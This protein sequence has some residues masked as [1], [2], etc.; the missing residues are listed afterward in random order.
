ML[1]GKTSKFPI[2]QEIIFGVDR[3]VLIDY[4]HPNSCLFS[5]ILNIGI[6][7]ATGKRFSINFSPRRSKKGIFKNLLQHS[8]EF[9][10]NP[11]NQTS[12]P[13]FPILR[14]LLVFIANNNTGDLGLW[15]VWYLVARLYP[16]LYDQIVLPK[17]EALNWFLNQAS[18][19]LQV[20]DMWYIWA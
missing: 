6:D 8:C 5:Q 16:R 17:T 12:Y 4:Y 11:L 15:A 18:I 7:L 10:S 1:W 2:I 19:F 9:Y 14:S 20:R 3:D 13:N